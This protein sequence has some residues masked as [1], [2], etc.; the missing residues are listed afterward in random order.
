MYHMMCIVLWYKVNGKV[1]F[2]CLKL[3]YSIQRQYTHSINFI[4]TN[5]C[6]WCFA[7]ICFSCK[8]KCVLKITFS[9]KKVFIRSLHHQEIEYN[10][11]QMGGGAKGASEL[12]KHT[13]NC[14]I[15]I[16]FNFFVF[17]LIPKH[18]GPFPLEARSMAKSS[19][20]PRRKYPFKENHRAHTLVQK[21][22]FWISGA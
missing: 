5:S 9:S 1:L 12:M 14:C 18:T 17:P 13:Q 10:P 4:P 19:K 22:I 21:C 7:S 3:I 2:I 20:K 16:V 8:E 11:V 15:R 6:C